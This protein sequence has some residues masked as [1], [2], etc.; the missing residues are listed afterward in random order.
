MA[1]VKQDTKGIEEQILSIE[2]RK[3]ALEVVL[4]GSD[5]AVDAYNDL[6]QAYFKGIPS[7]TEGQIEALGRYGQ[8][9]L[10]IRKSL[11]HGTTRLDKWDMLRHM[12][13]DLD[14]VVEQAGLRRKRGSIG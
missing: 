2:Y 14:T 9:L 3:T 12:V 1:K 10:A 8:L 11:G 4:V 5:E 6:M 7:S 13:T